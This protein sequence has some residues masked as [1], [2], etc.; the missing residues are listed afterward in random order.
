MADTDLAELPGISATALGQLPAT[1]SPRLA[2]LEWTVVALAAGDPLA[3]VRPRG[4]IRAALALLFGAAAPN[5]LGSDRLEALRRVSVHAWHRGLAIPIAEIR[6][7]FE[8]GFTPGQLELVVA[9]IS[10]GRSMRPRRT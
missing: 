1:R 9:S 10:L 8:A 4:R 2:P 6:A 3:S 5:R 7:F